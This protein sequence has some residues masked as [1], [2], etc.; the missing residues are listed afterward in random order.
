MSKRSEIERVVNTLH[1]TL[2]NFSNGTLSSQFQMLCIS[3]LICISVVTGFEWPIKVVES[4]SKGKYV[5]AKRDI[6]PGE[7]V[8]IE[9]EPLLFYPFQ[10]NSYKIDGIP[11]EYNPVFGLYSAAKSI[12]SPSKL[13]KILNLFGPTEGM[14]ADFVRDIGRKYIKFVKL[15]GDS[16]FACDEDVEMLVKVNMAVKLNSFED[17]NGCYLFDEM[18]R[19][20]HSCIANCVYCFDDKSIRCTAI[21]TIEEGEELT[22]SYNSQSDF[23]P[24]HVRRYHYLSLH[25]FTCH[26]P[27]CDAPGD[28]T[29]QFDCV[30]PACKV[31]MMACQPLNTWS[32]LFPD[33][34]YEGVEYVEPHLLPCT[35]CHR[36]APVDYQT[37][38]F[39]LEAIMPQLAMS[40][41]KTFTRLMS[42][43]LPVPDCERVLHEIASYNL[44][45]RHLLVEAVLQVKLMLLNSVQLARGG[46]ETVDQEHSTAQECI[47]ILQKVNLYPRQELL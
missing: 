28:D 4:Q 22:I 41:A 24:T 37:K 15:G 1:S 3:L 18:C 32:P 5:V 14:R 25:D 45:R 20:S 44:P 46:A 31:V 23:E 35:E 43:K 40:A 26:C 7:L 11:F 27:R 21:K 30:D 9:K 13:D 8:L 38:M 17:E 47:D 34:N 6:L 39:D 12:N 42:A 36:A 10:Q 33:R 29:R 16:K 19:F 2:P